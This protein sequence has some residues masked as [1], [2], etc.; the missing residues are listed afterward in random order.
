[1]HMARELGRTKGLS[2]EDA[3]KLAASKLAEQQHHSSLWYRVNATRG[4]TGG[5]RLVP[6]VNEAL[7]DV[8][9]KLSG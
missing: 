7:R 6:K 5:H 8:R 4:L 2:E 3:A 1:M 9:Y